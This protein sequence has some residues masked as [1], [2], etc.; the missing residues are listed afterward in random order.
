VQCCVHSIKPS[1]SPEAFFA[2]IWID[3]PLKIIV[4]YPALAAFHCETLEK[5]LRA[6]FLNM[7]SHPGAH[8]SNAADLLKDTAQLQAV[9]LPEGIYKATQTLTLPHRGAVNELVH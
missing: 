1:E 3:I 8:C 9:F 7:Q 2:K 4:Q 6:R 5:V